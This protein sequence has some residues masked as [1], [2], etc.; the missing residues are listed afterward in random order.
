MNDAAR[1]SSVCREMDRCLPQSQ[2][3]YNAYHT[4]YRLP[5]MLKMVDPDKGPS[6]NE[7]RRILQSN[8]ATTKPPDRSPGVLYSMACQSTIFL[9]PS[10]PTFAHARDIRWRRMRFAPPHILTTQVK[11]TS[12]EDIDTPPP[13]DLSTSPTAGKLRQRPGSCILCI[14]LQETLMQ[15]ARE[16]RSK[17]STIDGKGCAGTADHAGSGCPHAPQPKQQGLATPNG[18]E[19]AVAS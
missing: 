13:G 7:H 5:R 16:N 19:S 17:R 18:V 8:Q 6:E 2:R 12:A 14:G 11:E 4:P 3:S 10:R 15:T 1:N 9:G